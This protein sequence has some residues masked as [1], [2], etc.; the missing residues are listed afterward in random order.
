VLGSAG[1]FIT[2][3]AALQLVERGIISLDETVSP[4][5]PELDSLPLIKRGTADESFSLCPPT[6]RITLRHLFLHMSGISSHADPLVNDYFTSDCAKLEH[7]EDATIIVK[8]FSIPLVFEPGEGFAYGY[9]IYWT[10][11][12]ITRLTGD[13]VGY[14]QEN[15]F[16]PLKM[17]SSTYKP[18]DC[19]GIWDRR[20]R[21]VER[22]MDK[23]VPTDDA[24]QGLICSMADMG[25]ILGD[26]ISP[27]PRLLKKEHIDLIFT[28]QLTPSSVALKDLRC[29]HDNYAFCAGKPGDDGP[30][31]VNWSMGGLVVE[32]EL[33]LSH[34][35]KGTVVWEGMPNVLWA[36]NREKGL[37]AFFVTQLIPV[38]DI[39]ANE[40]ATTFM[41]DAWNHFG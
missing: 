37:G 38:G 17:M 5:L 6:N 22:K 25:V 26:L 21:M 29:D 11:L 24:S 1:K 7:P 32:K 33:P 12:L 15:I 2:H 16:K 8:K 19:P 41:R 10:Q 3:I 23:L 30:P 20:L 40:L 14:M 34:L 13:F 36:M 9:S 27:N 18:Q 31:T 35:P 4:H 39:I 28:G